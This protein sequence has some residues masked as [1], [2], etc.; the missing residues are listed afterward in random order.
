M[1]YVGLILLLLINTPVFSMNDASYLSIAQEALKNK[2]SQTLKYKGDAERAIKQVESIINKNSMDSNRMLNKSELNKSV[3]IMIFVSFSMPDESLKAYMRDAKKIHASLVIRGLIDNSFKKT[4]QHISLLIK[5]SG[6]NGIE[7]N[8]LWFKR[9][10]IKSVPTV[11]VVNNDGECI[12]NN[13][14]QIDS[15]YDSVAGNIT[16]ISALRLIRDRGINKEIAKVA[17]DKL[18]ARGNA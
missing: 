15:D 3:N 4:F 5:Q 1:K 12:R 10:N 2:D 18:E 6:G 16:L 13:T 7:L 9:F 17:I 11:V 8:P 14:C